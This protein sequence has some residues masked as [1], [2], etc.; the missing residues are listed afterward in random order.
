MRRT[1]TE[2]FLWADVRDYDW[3]HNAL[4]WSI[5]SDRKRTQNKYK[6]LSAALWSCFVWQ[7][8]IEGFAYWN[9]IYNT[10]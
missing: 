8:T 9:N 2:W 6:S 3:A 1:A 7:E 10:L 4:N 5:L